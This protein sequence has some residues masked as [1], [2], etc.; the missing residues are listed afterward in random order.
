M[1][2]IFIIDLWN[3]WE[4]HIANES[5]LLARSLMIFDNDLSFTSQIPNGEHL[6][7]DPDFDRHTSFFGVDFGHVQTAHQKII[8]Y[9][10]GL[11]S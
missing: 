9:L 11:I 4:T 7:S 2:F 6:L 5:V 10:A 8:L 1:V 3:Y